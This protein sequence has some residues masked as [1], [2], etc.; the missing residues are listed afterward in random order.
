MDLRRTALFNHLVGA[1]ELR[2]RNPLTAEC[3]DILVIDE[4][5]KGSRAESE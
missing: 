1:G 2:R 4:I 5:V 3:P